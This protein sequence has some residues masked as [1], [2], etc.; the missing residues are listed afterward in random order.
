MIFR[1]RLDWHCGGALSVGAGC[2][3][4]G[5][6]CLDQPLGIWAGEARSGSEGS[7]VCRGHRFRSAHRR[8]HVS[9]GNRCRFI[10]VRAK[11]ARRAC[12]YK[13]HAS[14]EHRYQQ[15]DNSERHG[16][17]SPAFVAFGAPSLLRA[18]WLHGQ[19][20]SALP[21]LGGWTHRPTEMLVGNQRGAARGWPSDLRG[22]MR[23]LP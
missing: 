16:K 12:R 4:C 17:H 5:Q 7:A 8:G 15:K 14:A 11:C 19:N 23:A 13:A 20:L 3:G 1:P 6:R 10:V 21:Q 22:L 9:A 18:Q 2:R